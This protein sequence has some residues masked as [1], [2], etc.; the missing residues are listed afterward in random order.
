MVAGTNLV[1][2]GIPSLGCG[3]G[4]S[5]IQC[6]QLNDEAAQLWSSPRLLWLALCW[7][8]VFFGVSAPVVG[9]CSQQ[10]M[11]GKESALPEPQGSWLIQTETPSLGP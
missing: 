11:V 10:S 1:P 9:K 4:G 3:E 2:K 5:F 8:D 6:K 7:Q